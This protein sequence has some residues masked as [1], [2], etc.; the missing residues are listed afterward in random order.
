MHIR[1]QMKEDQWGQIKFFSET[2]NFCSLRPG[3]HL[4]YVHKHI[5]RD[6]IEPLDLRTGK[7]YRPI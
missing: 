4:D 7:C 5:L 3:G 6:H 1:H 2:E